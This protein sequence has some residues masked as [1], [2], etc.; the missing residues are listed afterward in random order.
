MLHSKVY[1][2]SNVSTHA[3]SPFSNRTKLK[4]VTSLTLFYICEA[5]QH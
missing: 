3:L 5:Y 2:K 1:V 4:N